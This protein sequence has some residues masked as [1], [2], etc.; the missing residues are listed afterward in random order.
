MWMMILIFIFAM[1]CVFV[2]AFFVILSDS[3]TM[4]EIDRKL[5]KKIRGKENE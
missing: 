5:A 1:L 4:K 3:E 2:T